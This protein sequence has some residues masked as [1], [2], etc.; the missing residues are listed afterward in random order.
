MTSERRAFAPTPLW[1][2]AVALGLAG[3]ASAPPS[4]PREYLDE[5]TAATVT[6]AGTAMVF[7]LERPDLGV[8]ARDYVTLTTVDVNTSGKHVSHVI[9][10]AWSTL[11]KRAAG[12][13]AEATY[14]LVVEDRV[15]PLAVLPDGFRTLGIAQSPLQPPSRYA[16]PLAAGVS[17]DVLALYADAPSARIVRQRAGVVERFERWSATGTR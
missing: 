17:R 8:N 16:V 12:N 10:Y 15:L 11:D 3:C 5:T 6:V 7:A 1:L 13:D 9:G 2:L 14:E 4:E